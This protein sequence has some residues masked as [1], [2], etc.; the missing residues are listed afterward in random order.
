MK[1]CA[2]NSITIPKGLNGSSLVSQNVYYY[3]SNKAY[4]FFNVSDETFLATGLLNISCLDPDIYCAKT[5]LDSTKYYVAISVNQ[6][7]GLF[8]NPLLSSA[9]C[10]TNKTLISSVL[11]FEESFRV[12]MIALN[13]KTIQFNETKPFK[14]SDIP[15]GYS[16]GVLRAAVKGVP[17]NN[18]Y[19]NRQLFVMEVNV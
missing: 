5:I 14:A 9:I 2:F 17:P 12:T 8:A 11:T 18:R 1:T 4:G 15:I 7:E 6:V 3:F 13:K 10:I 19:Y 16:I